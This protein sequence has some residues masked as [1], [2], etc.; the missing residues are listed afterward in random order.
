MSATTI[1]TNRSNSSAQSRV[2]IFNSKMYVPELML[3]NETPGPA[4]YSQQISTNSGPSYSF[5][6]EDRSRYEQFYKE[7][8]PEHYFYPVRD[9]APTCN[10][11]HV[12]KFTRCNL[13]IFFIY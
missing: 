13:Y 10:M 1:R 6:R 5:G 11:G 2:T 9:K 8:T 3:R 12:S 4:R 7:K